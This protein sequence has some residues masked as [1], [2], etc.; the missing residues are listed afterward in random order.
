MFPEI[1]TCSITEAEGEMDV[2]KKEQCP[3]IYLW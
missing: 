1:L 3:N 2:G